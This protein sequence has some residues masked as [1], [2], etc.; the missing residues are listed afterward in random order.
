M[1]LISQE[2]RLLAFF[3]NLERGIILVG[4]TLPLWR[5]FIH[6]QFFAVVEV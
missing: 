6:V 3:L 4:Y 5:Q 1:P 2:L